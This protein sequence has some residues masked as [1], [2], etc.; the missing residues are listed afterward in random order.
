[1]RRISHDDELTPRVF[2][3]DACD[4]FAINFV[5]SGGFDLGP[6]ALAAGDAFTCR[7][8]AIF[9][10]TFH[11]RKRCYGFQVNARGVQSDAIWTEAGGVWDFSYDGIWE[12]EARLT[13]SG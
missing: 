11:D 2:E 8:V 7:P 4:H 9:L 12:S 6:R 10:D 13:G 3:D 1:V 5:E